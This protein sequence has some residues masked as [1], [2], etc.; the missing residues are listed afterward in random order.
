ME[1]RSV[2]TDLEN[3]VVWESDQSDQIFGKCTRTKIYAR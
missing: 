1:G 2:N 3:C